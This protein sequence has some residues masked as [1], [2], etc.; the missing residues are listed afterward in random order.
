M[1]PGRIRTWNFL[2]TNPHLCHC[3]TDAF[4]IMDE[5]LKI[6]YQNVKTL[7]RMY[8]TFF[9]FLYS[10]TTILGTIY[11]P[12]S[13]FYT[14]AVNHL[15]WAREKTPTYTVLWKLCIHMVNILIGDIISAINF[16]INATA[17]VGQL[18]RNSEAYFGWAKKLSQWEAGR[19]LPIRR[20]LFPY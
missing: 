18:M 17:I 16:H 12:T 10:V 3:T 8:G 2:I 5:I 11:Y 20:G 4:V 7:D 13:M 19:L 14:S 1:L 9:E 6:R 15:Q